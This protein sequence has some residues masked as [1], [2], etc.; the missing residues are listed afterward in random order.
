MKPPRALRLL[1]WMGFRGFG[2]IG[3]NKKLNKMPKSASPE[4]SK[5]WGTSLVVRLLV[6][7]VAPKPWHFGKLRSELGPVD[8]APGKVGNHDAWV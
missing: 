7:L 1:Y 5:A 3:L 8:L 4:S 2:F 6:P